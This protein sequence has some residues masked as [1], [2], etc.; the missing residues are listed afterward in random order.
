MKHIKKTIALILSIITLSALILTS[1]GVDEPP[2]V[3]DPVTDKA[4]DPVTDPATDPVTD[5]VTDPATDPVTEPVTDPVTEPVTEPVTTEPPVTEPVITYVN[6]MTGLP[7]EEDLSGKRPVSVSIDNVRKAQPTVGLSYADVVVELPFEGFE[8]RMMAIFLDYTDLP[9]VGNIRSARDYMVRLAADFDSILVHAGSDTDV[10]CRQLAL[11]AIRYGFAVSYLIKTDVIKYA[12]EREDLWTEG[13][14]TINGLDYYPNPMFRDENR[15]YTMAVE[16]STMINGEVICDCIDYKNYRTDIKTDFSYPYVIGDENSV[17][18][19]AKAEHVFLPYN[20]WQSNYGA[21]YV[22][23]AEKGLYMRSNYSSE[24]S[25]DGATNE[26]LGFKNLIILQLSTKPFPNDEKN[27][28]NVD[29]VGEG[30]GYYCVN[31]M[32]EEITWIRE[33]A[34]AGLVI[35]GADGNVLD[36]VPGKVMINVYPTEYV[37]NM[38]LN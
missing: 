4:T 33:D 24:P 1:C 32:C 21:E 12:A 8:T 7:T 22:Y 20:P 5:P 14:E 25:I 34:N 15:L 35:K 19:A 31:G 29:Y 36:I 38:K 28:L 23:D 16:H 10:G 30:K 3:T 2:I 27:R 13:V 17:P 18:T 26:Q 9:T 11:N 37:D 6:P